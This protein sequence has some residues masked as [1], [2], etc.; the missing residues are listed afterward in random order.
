M[1]AF[2]SKC[3]FVPMNT[4]H[5][6]SY[7]ASSGKSRPIAH[8]FNVAERRFGENFDGSTHAAVIKMMMHALGPSPS[9][10]FRHV[11]PSGRGCDVTMKDEFKVHVTQEELRRV[12]QVSRFSGDDPVV[13]MNANFALAVFVKRKQVAGDYPRFEAA[14]EKTLQGETTLR[15]LKG[16]GVSGLSQHV[17]PSEM[18]RKGVVAVMETHSLGSALVVDGV[19]HHYAGQ[20]AVGDRYGYV[21]FPDKPQVVSLGKLTASERPKDIWG[22]FYQ[23]VQG[24]CVTVS[25]IKAAMMRFGQSPQA[26][27]RQVT[28]TSTGYEVVMRDSFTLRLTHE[29]LNKA[30][31]ASWLAGADQQLL[32]DANFLYAVSAKRAQLENNDFRASQGYDVALATLSDGEFPG[33]ALRRLGLFGYL[34]ESD[35]N[36]LAKGAI[37]T[38]AGNGHSVVV[39]NG[40]FDLYGQKHD[41]ASSRWMNTGFRALKLV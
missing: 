28:A 39:I 31:A 27:Y 5:T 16:M 7:E 14:L 1:S 22:G 26:I 29:E 15:V 33:Q 4:P 41:L 17:P 35:V 13:V 36:E 21:L 12:A 30:R 40:A 20:R 23:G 11:V 37:G 34:R 32:E 38:L 18:K 9:D 24:N 19:G 10:M 2:I 25:A 8:A 6:C 3:P